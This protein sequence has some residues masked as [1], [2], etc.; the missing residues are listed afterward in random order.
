MVTARRRDISCAHVLLWPVFLGLAGFG[1]G[2]GSSAGSN[3]AAREDAGQG[4]AIGPDVADADANASES[5]Y[6]LD[7]AR[8]VPGVPRCDGEF[9]YQMCEPDG[10]WGS[11]RSCAGYSE[12]GT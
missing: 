7:G 11:S 10:T 6:E 8:C 1:C 12:N 2:S 4:D 5:G 3:G 9:G